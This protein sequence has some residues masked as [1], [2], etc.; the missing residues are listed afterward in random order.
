MELVMSTEEKCLG[1]EGHKESVLKTKVDILEY[2]ALIKAEER[3]ET[4]DRRINTEV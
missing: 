4:E 2:F 1:L 3:K